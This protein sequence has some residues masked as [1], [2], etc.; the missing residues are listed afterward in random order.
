MSTVLDGKVAKSPNVATY[1]L[2]LRNG[3]SL[4][5]CER[6]AK[7]LFNEEISHMGFQTYRDALDP[8]ELV[9]QFLPHADLDLM[10]DEEKHL[11]QAI[12]LMEKRIDKLWKREETMP[13]PMS[14]LDKMLAQLADM[15]VQLANIRGKGVSPT[16]VRNTINAQF[17]KFSASAA[18]LG[19]SD[20]DIRQ[21]VSQLIDSANPQNGEDG[22]I[23]GESSE[24]LALEVH[25]QEL[26]HTDSQS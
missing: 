17:N 6:L 22:V 12:L 7:D 18:R 11:M 20:E 14:A 2:W 9:P 3:K 21:W 10:L 16:H 19:E 5:E 8:K 23:R 1:S 13:L 24:G 26:P 4:R 25:S 15:L